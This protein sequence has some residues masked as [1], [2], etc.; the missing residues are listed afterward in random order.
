MMVQLELP[1]TSAI[2]KVDL[3]QPEER[4]RLE[5]FVAP[6]GSAL[7]HDI[8]EA[9]L[10]S[11][12]QRFRSLNQ[13]L[14]EMLDE[15]SLVSFIPIRCLA[16]RGSVFLHICV[17]VCV[18]SFTTCNDT[19]AAAVFAHCCFLGLLCALFRSVALVG[20]KPIRS[21]R[22]ATHTPP[23]HRCLFSGAFTVVIRRAGLPQPHARAHRDFFFCLCAAV[24]PACFCC[25]V[26][27]HSVKD[28]D[29]LERL[30]AHVDVSIQY[31]EDHEVQVPKDLDE[32]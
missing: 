5:E 13:A 18:L 21:V 26:R 23:H 12:S 2:T 10:K 32:D 19:R 15:Y 25:W 4:E 22:H 11:H 3:V 1:H 20:A 29:T 31:G 14:G 7:A 24:C 28:L 9:N 16:C 6:S 30:T 8:R 17:R 27:A